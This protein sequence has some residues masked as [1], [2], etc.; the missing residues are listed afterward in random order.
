MT[1]RIFQPAVCALFV[2]LIA[3]VARAQDGASGGDGPD[4]SIQQPVPPP[5]GRLTFPPM[6]GDVSGRWVPLGAAPVDQAGAGR[7]GYVV[8]G[9]D[10]NVAAPGANR[11]SFHAVS[12]NN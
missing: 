8:A 12:A 3:G 1:R 5:L 11:L 7:R 6:T 10:A 9:D 4:Q 2:F